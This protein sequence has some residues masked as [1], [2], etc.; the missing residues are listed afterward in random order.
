M[1]ID[2]QIFHYNMMLNTRLK[3]AASFGLFWKLEQKTRQGGTYKDVVAVTMM[4]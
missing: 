2:L 1:P 4:D 3:L